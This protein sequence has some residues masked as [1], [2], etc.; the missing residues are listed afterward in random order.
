MVQLG[1]QIDRVRPSKLFNDLC[2]EEDDEL[3][4]D[5][6]SDLKIIYLFERLNSQAQKTRWLRF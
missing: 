3:Y 4:E 6:G 5:E 1:D 2:T